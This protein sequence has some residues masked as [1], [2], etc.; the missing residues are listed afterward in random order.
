MTVRTVAGGTTPNF[1]WIFGGTDKNSLS[2]P[3]LSAIANLLEK[4][5]SI[6][7]H[8]MENG[9]PAVHRKCYLFKFKRQTPNKVSFLVTD[10]NIFD[11]FDEQS[12]SLV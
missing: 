5:H 4:S 7:K 6:S 1:L 8:R 11:T 2:A 3:L 12:K 9:K 10:Q